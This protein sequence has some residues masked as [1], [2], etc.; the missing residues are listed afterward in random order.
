[1]FI[2]NLRHVKKR[3]KYIMIVLVVLIAIGLLSTF[4]YL[5]SSFNGANAADGTYTENMI[6]NLESSA[7]TYTK[8]LK[9]D[10]ANT[11]ALANAAS[12]YATLGA[13]QN[14]LLDETAAQKSYTSAKDYANQLIAY[15][16]E[17]G[18]EEGDWATAYGVLFECDLATG[19]LDGA[20]TAF[21][22]S[23]EKAGLNADILNSYTTFM[24]SYMYFT[25]ASEDL[26]SYKDYLPADAEEFASSIDSMIST[27][28]WQQMLYE[29]SNNTAGSDDTVE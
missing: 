14:L 21:T 24:T 3:S 25:E 2:E 23:W 18:G 22:E 5:G 11:E 27:V 4:A 19:N 28:Q 10:A 9:Q 13:Y 15:Y 12:T 8:E 6:A 29:Y 16:E 20:R 1:M 7:K 26:Q 17:N